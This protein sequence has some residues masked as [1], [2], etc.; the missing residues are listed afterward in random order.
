MTGPGAPPDAIEPIRLAFDVA[1]PVDHA[2]RIWTADTSRWWPFS[3]TVSVEDELQ[4]IFEPRVGGRIF[5][6]TRGGAE[7]DWGRV[8]GWEPPRRLSYTWH[9]RVD[10][11]DATDVEIRF[12]D[13]GPTTR[14]EIEH[15]GWERLGTATGQARRDANRAGWG[16]LLPHYIE[17]CAQD[18]A[19]GS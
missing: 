6:R 19:R 7:H 17:V 13:Q 10:A 2:F 14:V 15:R 5:E 4:I 3:H 18:A 16:G 1:C 8:T 9:L 12:L 11:A